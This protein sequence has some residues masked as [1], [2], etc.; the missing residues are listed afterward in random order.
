MPF[1]ESDFV[2]LRD[3]LGLDFIFELVKMVPLGTSPG[4]V[5]RFCVK[6]EPWLTTWPALPN[7]TCSFHCIRLYAIF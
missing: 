6:V 5:F 2:S 1:G 3:G 7:R 4:G